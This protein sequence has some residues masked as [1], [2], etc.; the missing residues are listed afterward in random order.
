MRTITGIDVMNGCRL[1]LHYGAESFELDFLP[2][3]QQGGVFTPLGDREFFEQV[4]I[5]PN[6]RY[7]VWP[8]ELDFCADALWLEAHSG[9]S[10]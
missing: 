3:A 5:G 9:V 4:A 6:G 1:R 7:L 2:L 10:R 8:D